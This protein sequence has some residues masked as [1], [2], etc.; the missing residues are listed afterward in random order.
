M[1][2]SGYLYKRGVFVWLF[3]AAVLAVAARAADR[4]ACADAAVVAVDSTFRFAGHEGRFALEIDAPGIVTLEVSGAGPAN[5][6]SFR[7]VRAAPAD[8]ALVPLFL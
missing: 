4:G 3:L 2:K 1:Y 5:A 7:E 6:V 8:P